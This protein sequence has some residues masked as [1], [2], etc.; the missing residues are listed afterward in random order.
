MCRP[1][2]SGGGM[3]STPRGVTVSK[4]LVSVA[5]FFMS[6]VLFVRCFIIELVGLMTASLK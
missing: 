6:C 2:L 4:L 1:V 3:H 5:V